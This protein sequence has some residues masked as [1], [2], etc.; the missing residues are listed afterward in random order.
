MAAYHAP[1]LAHP[2]AAALEV[3][4]GVIERRRRTRRWRRHGR[5][6]KALVDSKK[7]L[8]VRMGVE[9][10]H[11]PGFMHRHGDTRATT[12]RSTKRARS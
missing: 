3:L 12:S 2:D 8:S 6:Y 9:E 5:L 7:A 4:A 11:D 1:A 10:L